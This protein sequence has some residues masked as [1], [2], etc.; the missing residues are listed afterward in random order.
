MAPIKT[1]GILG[2]K[3]VLKV[4]VIEAGKMGK[5][6]DLR[7]FDKGQIV[8]MTWTEQ[9]LVPRKGLVMH[10]GAKASSSGLIPQKS[11]LLCLGS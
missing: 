7:H 2:S 8:M 5:R 4:E 9:L 3:S 10:M 11:Y 1:G 6:K